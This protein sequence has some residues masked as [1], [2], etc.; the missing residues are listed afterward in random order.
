MLCGQH[1]N[2]DLQ[3]GVINVWRV[4]IFNYGC[5][6]HN[7]GHLWYPRQWQKPFM[8]QIAGWVSILY[9]TMAF[10]TPF[11]HQYI[12]DRALQYCKFQPIRCPV[13]TTETVVDLWYR[14]R[15]GFHRP[16]LVSKIFFS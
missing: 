10:S 9:W 15:V 7:R 13:Q 8:F 5:P 1:G 6:H 12:G 4:K 16:F 3:M 2:L 14:S 11:L